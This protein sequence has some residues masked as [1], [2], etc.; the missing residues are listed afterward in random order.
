MHFRTTL[1]DPIHVKIPSSSLEFNLKSMYM[2][3]F[4]QLDELLYHLTVPM[5]TEKEPISYDM[6]PWSD[7]LFDELLC[8]VAAQ[9]STEEWEDKMNI[10]EP[11]ATLLQPQL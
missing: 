9:L 10:N 1:D 2:S 3:G 11:L 6:Y 7:K 8:E 5:W 4:D